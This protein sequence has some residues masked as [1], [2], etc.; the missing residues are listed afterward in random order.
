MRFFRPRC[1]LNRLRKQFFGKKECP[2]KTPGVKAPIIQSALLARLK[3]CPCYK[4]NQERV[5]PKPVKF[6]HARALTN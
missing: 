3:P 2:K 1:E 6:A 4:T 5:F